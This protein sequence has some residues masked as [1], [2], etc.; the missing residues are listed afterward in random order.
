MRMIVEAIAGPGPGRR[1]SLVAG[2]AVSVG[3]TEWADVSFPRDPLMSGT[4]FLLETDASGCYI[5]DKGSRNGTFV[6]GQRITQKTPLRDGDRIV[7]GQTRFA[8]RIEGLVAA[9]APGAGPVVS[10][11]SP[12]P[13]GKRREDVDVVFPPREEPGPI[14]ADSDTSTVRPPPGSPV[15]RTP[16]A[17]EPQALQG[18]PLP[19]PPESRGGRSASGDMAAGAVGASATG[20]AAS[21]AAPGAAAPSPGKAAPPGSPAEAWNLPPELEPLAGKSFYATQAPPPKKPATYTAERCDSGLTLLRG[22]L[23]EIAPAELAVRLAQFCPLYLVVDF[24]HLGM[25]APQDLKRRDYVFGWL[26]PV[27]AAGVSP[28][29][30]SQDELPHWPQLIDQAWGKDAAVCLFSRMQ[31]G[32]LVEHMQAVCRHRQRGGERG[33]AVIGCCWP[34]V[35]SAMLAHSPASTVQSLLAGIEAVLVELPDLPETWQVFGPPELRQYFERAGLVAR[36]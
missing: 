25:P 24:N 19:M 27:A 29:I 35:L 13:P 21:S 30:V 31:K 22:N 33:D 28:L 2:Q 9:E 36:S 7:A 20:A 10:P 11:V 12:P 23:S 6:N 18:I 4:H 5:T 17:P 1:I 16:L 3:R 34:S 8:V 15:R 14:A 32:P 26:D